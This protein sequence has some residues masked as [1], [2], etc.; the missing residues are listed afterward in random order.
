[1]ALKGRALF[2][3]N[4]HIMMSKNRHSKYRLV[5]S[6]LER[7]PIKSEPQTTFYVHTISAG[8]SNFLKQLMNFAVGTCIF[9]SSYL[10]KLESFSAIAKTTAFIYKPKKFSK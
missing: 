7:P 9:I 8:P 1:M 5:P 4:L 2:S 6:R 3:K 10:G